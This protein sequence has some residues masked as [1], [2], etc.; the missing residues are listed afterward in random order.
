MHEE[1]IFAGYK[2][3]SFQTIYFNHYIATVSLVLMN[4]IFQKVSVGITN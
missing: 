1:R 2:D 4:T 3:T